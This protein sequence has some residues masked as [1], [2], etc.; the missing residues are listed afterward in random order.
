VPYVIACAGYVTKSSRK[1]AENAAEKAEKD[2]PGYKAME[3]L[4]RERLKKGEGNDGGGDTAFQAHQRQL[5][6][7][8]YRFI[9][10]EGSESESEGSESGLRRSERI[11][12]RG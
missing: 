1:D 9:E 12:E 4:L 3:K 6:T 5:A 2:A 11:C 7:P 8:G 10:S